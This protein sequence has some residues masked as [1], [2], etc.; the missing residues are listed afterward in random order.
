MKLP[1]CPGHHEYE[2]LA[3]WMIEKMLP[4]HIDHFG[5][6]NDGW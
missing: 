3:E 4:D 5:L 2:T 1:G 6:W